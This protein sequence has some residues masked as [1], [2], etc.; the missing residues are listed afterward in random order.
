MLTDIISILKFATD[1]Q[2]RNTVGAIL[3][4]ASQKKPNW[5]AQIQLESFEFNQSNWALINAFTNELFRKI[6]ATKISRTKLSRFKSVYTELLNNAYNHGCKGKSRWKISVKCIYSRWFIQLEVKDNGKGFIVD[7][8]LEKVKNERW[9][10]ERKGRS[11][12]ELA[13]DLSDSIFIDGKNSRITIVI[14]GEDR[15]NIYKSIEKHGKHDL[16]IITWADKDEWSFL[17]PDWE[18]LSN[19]LNSATQRLILVRFAS[20]SRADEAQVGTKAIGVPPVEKEDE[21]YEEVD[22]DFS[23]QELRQAR[24][25]ITECGLDTNHLFAYIISSYWAYTDLKELETENLRF[26][27]NEPDAKNWLLKKGKS[28]FAKES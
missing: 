26:F 24:P 19:I 18:P 15:I 6:S 5:K 22:K 28:F 23:T 14:A 2:T 9:N 12:L 21:E 7:S 8:A 10:D 20:P 25:I 27:R 17:A 13:R 11:G 4:A 1:P 3:N 16:L